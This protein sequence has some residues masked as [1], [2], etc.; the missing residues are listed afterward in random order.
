MCSFLA[1]YLQ[2]KLAD[3]RVKHLC[4]VNS[5]LREAKRFGVTISF[6]NG[7][8]MLDSGSPQIRCLSFCNAGFPHST[9]SAYGK[10][11][12]ISGLLVEKE[13]KSYLYTFS[14]HSNKQKRA[15]VS[16]GSAEIMAL[17][18]GYYDAEDFTQ[19]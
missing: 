6:K 5:V 19:G 11:G 3:L 16:A 14:W 18:S 13:E 4:E 9:S 1:S 15:A 2:Q 8:G 10:Q 7:T 12:T 17:H